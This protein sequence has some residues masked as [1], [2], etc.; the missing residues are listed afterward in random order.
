[1]GD[2]NFKSFLKVSALL[3]IFVLIIYIPQISEHKSTKSFFN[4]FKE[5]LS[6]ESENEQATME[7]EVTKK[8]NSNSGSNNGGDTPIFEEEDFDDYEDDDDYYDDDDD[9]DNN[10]DDNNENEG[11]NNETEDNE[12]EDNESNSFGGGN[13]GDDIYS[14]ITDFETGSLSEHWNSQFARS[15][16]GI[17]VSDIV[18]NGNYAIKMNVRYGDVA[19]QHDLIYNKSRVEL[20]MKLPYADEYPMDGSVVYY[21][22]SVYF[23]EDFY[24]NYSVEHDGFNIVG[25]WFHRPEVGQSWEEWENNHGGKKGSPSVSIRYEELED[26]THGLGILT[27][28]NVE[29]P[30]TN[31]ASK[32]IQLGEWN[33]IIF[34]VKWSMTNDGYIEAW[35]NGAKF[36]D[37]KYYAKNMYTSTPK[38]LK[39]GLYRG[40]NV[41]SENDIYYDEI[42]I[43]GSYEEVDPSNY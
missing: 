1:M 15:D 14:I 34:G 42:R 35:L 12:T 37:G 2:D 10:D 8:P 38:N 41:L 13:M 31:I 11:S 24:Y 19:V 7:D 25:Q 9:D 39:L 4:S 5:S 28:P 6:S 22:W 23:P 29:S 20:S 32:E 30:S 33:D 40:P 26:G 18:R 21:G 17:I 27:R 43:G 3:L 36:T 16:S